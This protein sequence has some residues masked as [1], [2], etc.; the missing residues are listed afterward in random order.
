M[1]DQTLYDVRSELLNAQGDFL[2]SQTQR[3][4]LRSLKLA[5]EP[6]EFGTSFGLSQWSRSLC[7]DCQLDS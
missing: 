2:D 4:G 6:D 1:G 3:I 7:Q 5:Q